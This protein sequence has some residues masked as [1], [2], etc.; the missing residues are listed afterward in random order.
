MTFAI[1]GILLPLRLSSDHP[2][3]PRQHIGW[4][5]EA[6][7]LGGFEIDYQLELSRLLDGKISGLG[8]FDNFVYINRRAAKNVIFIGRIGNETASL[9]VLAPF[10]HRSQA[11]L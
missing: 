7:L 5:Y 4:N 2:I 1:I 9:Y 11:V 10:K 6:D 3:R 8:A